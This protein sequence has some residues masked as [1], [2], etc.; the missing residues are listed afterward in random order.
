MLLDRAGVEAVPVPRPAEFSARSRPAGERRGR[1]A[2]ARVHRPERPPR[3]RERPPGPSGPVRGR[4]AALCPGGITGALAISG[5]A[6]FPPGFR[7]YS[8]DAPNAVTASTQLF[9]A[10][11]GWM[12]QGQSSLLVRTIADGVE[13]AD[14]PLRDARTDTSSTGPSGTPLVGRRTGHRFP[15]CRM[16]IARSARARNGRSVVGGGGRDG[17]PPAAISGLRPGRFPV[18]REIGPSGPT[19]RPHHPVGCPEAG[20]H[21]DGEGAANRAERGDPHAAVRGGTDPGAICSEEQPHHVPDANGK[22]KV[23]HER[24]LPDRKCPLRHFGRW[25]RSHWSA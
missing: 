9:L 6:L 22:R 25:N 16:E 7:Q 12:G 20:G 8:V 5:Q 23:S 21:P 10:G 15:C 3:P 14:V 17:G 13:R 1:A 2:G 4:R 18:V 19:M 24:L 11:R